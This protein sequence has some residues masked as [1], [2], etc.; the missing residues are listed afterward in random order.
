VIGKD[1]VRFHAVYWPAF[2]M[3]AG[4]EVPR[5]IFSHGFIL[6]RGEKMSKSIGN[7]LDPFT[8]VDEYGVD[9][10]RYFCLREVPFGQDGNYSHEAIV[11]RINADLAND[12]GNLAHRSL[13]M[14]QRQCGGVLPEPGDLAAADEAI[15]QVTDAMIEHCRELM[16]TQ[17]LHKVIN[18]VWS[19]IAEANRYFAAEEPWAAANTDPARMGTILYV[20]SEVLRQVAILSQPAMPTAAGRLLD[21]LGIGT[22]ERTFDMLGKTHTRIRAGAKLPAPTPVFP[23]YIDRKTAVAS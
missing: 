17:A 19:V 21:L 8:L 23:R 3:S 7:V 13:T 10:F 20:T 15:L 22:A 1:I 18:C 9:Q 5:R 6:T 16:K 4:L 11:G 12:L 14:I 2:L